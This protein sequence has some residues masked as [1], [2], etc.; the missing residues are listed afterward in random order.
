MP[1]D[2]GRIIVTLIY[3]LEMRLFDPNIPGSLWSLASSFSLGGNAAQRQHDVELHKFP[4]LR[5][6]ATTLSKFSSRYPFSVWPERIRIPFGNVLAAR[7]S[8]TYMIFS[9]WLDQESNH[10][11]I[12]VGNHTANINGGPGPPPSICCLRCSSP[13]CQ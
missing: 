13:I 1:T 6:L 2:H 4:D 9:S 5:T 8:L 7:V 10:M 12:E 3:I 11:P